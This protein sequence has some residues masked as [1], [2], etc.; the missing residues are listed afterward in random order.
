MRVLDRIVDVP[1]AELLAPVA[2]RGDHLVRQVVEHRM[3]DE[4]VLLLLD[5]QPGVDGGDVENPLLA[6]VRPQQVL[7]IVQRQALEG[8]ERIRRA[9]RAGGP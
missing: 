3:Q 9:M 1:H 2:Q 5:R 6:V 7:G 4:V 8:A